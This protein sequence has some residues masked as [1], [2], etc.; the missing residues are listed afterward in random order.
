MIVRATLAAPLSH[1]QYQKN[2]DKGSDAKKSLPQPPY[3]LLFF[4]H[5]PKLPLHPFIKGTSPPPPISGTHSIPP[6]ASTS[7]GEEKMM[8]HCETHELRRK[9]GKLLEQVVF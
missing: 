7:G 1:P 8:W 5:G 4:L 3:H 2:S 9:I 6:P